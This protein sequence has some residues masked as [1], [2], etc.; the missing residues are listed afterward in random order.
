MYAYLAAA[1]HVGMWVAVWVLEILTFIALSR[2]EEDVYKNIS[3][4]DKDKTH[5]MLAVS[6]G[7][8]V[9]LGAAAL[10]LV[11]VLGTHIITPGIEDGGIP[12]G[13]TSLMSS[14]LKVSLFFSMMVAATSFLIFIMEDVTLVGPGATTCT[15]SKTCAHM[16]AANLLGAEEAF[17]N[18]IVALIALK[19]YVH[20]IMMNNMRAIVTTEDGVQ[21]VVSAQ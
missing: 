17:L 7:S 9:T 4:A 18:Y 2:H 15:T 14:G 21:Q 6:L 5:P 10:G 20:S 12:T 19:F 3:S 11:I 13:M 1:W 8:L 16:T